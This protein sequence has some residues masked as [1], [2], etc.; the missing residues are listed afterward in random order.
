MSD[1]GR[2]IGDCQHGKTREFCAECQVVMRMDECRKLSEKVVDNLSEEPFHR[3]ELI[4]EI[5]G[6]LEKLM[7]RIERLEQSLIDNGLSIQN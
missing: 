7:D 2:Q 1:S 4:G 3:A 5:T 6:I